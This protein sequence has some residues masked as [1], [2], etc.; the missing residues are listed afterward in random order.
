MIIKFTSLFLFVLASFITVA[1]NS[2]ETL[3]ATSVTQATYMKT[4]P[5]IADQIASGDFQEAIEINKEVNPKKRDANQ[6]VPGKGLPIGVDPLMHQQTKSSMIKGK[7]PILTFQAAAANVT[8]T[9]PT[10]AVGPNHFVNAWNSSFRIWDKEGNAMTPAASLG[11]IW[12]GQTMGDP[13]VMYDQIAD[14]FIITQFYGNG[15]LFA[16]SQG[17][18][19]I[20]SGWYTYQFPT[21]T[22]PD[23]PKYS[24]WSDGYYITSNKNSSSA[25]FSEVVYALDRDKMLTGDPSA[26]MIGFALPGIST[27][28]F[29]SPLGFN[30]TGP[31]M[32]PA[33]NAP[34]IYM[35]DDSWGGVSTDHLKI[36]NIN[37]DWDSPA[38]STISAAQ[39]IN[40]TP[41]D[42]LFDGGSFSNLPQPSGPDIDALQ[43]TIMYM[44]QYRRFNDHNSVVFNFVVDLTGS[45]NLAGIRW[46]ELRQENDGD[47]WEIFQEGTYSQPDGHSAY[48]GTMCMDA[49]GNIALAYTV[50]SNTVY[51]SL[52]YTGRFAT[53]DL[54]VMTIAEE[55]YAEG[56]SSSPFF[57]YGDYSQMTIDPEDDKTFWS[58][59]E[60]FNGGPRQNQVG[61]FKIAPD[62]ANDIGIISIDEPQN[63]ILTASEEITVTVR[64]FGVDDQSNFPVTYQIN[65][66][67]VITENFTGSLASNMDE[68]FTFS[69]LADLSNPGETFSIHAGTAL[70]TDLNPANDTISKAVT[71]LF[72]D[73]LGVTA[74]I[75]PES[76][77]YLS[78]EENI[79][80]T[81]YNYGAEIQSDF[82]ITYILND[83]TPVTET[84]T[85]S[86]NSE[87]FIDFEFDTPADFSVIGWHELKVT[88]DLSGD[89]NMDNDTLSVFVINSLCQP[90]LNCEQ[91]V[92][93]YNFELG[94]ITNETGCDP[95]GYGNY[96]NLST[97]L[98]KPAPHDLT[99]STEYG[100]TYVK[101]WIDYNDNFSFEEDEIV[102]DDFVIA[103]GQAAGNF[104][105]TMLLPVTN[106]ATL[107]EH[108]LR[109]KTNYNNNVPEDPCEETVF[110]E[111]EDYIVNIVLETGSDIASL[112]NNELHLINRGNNQYKVEYESNFMN[113]TMVLTIHDIRGNTL[114][115]N[116]VPS[117]NGSYHFEFD[118]SYAPKGVYLLRL[119]T[120]QFGKV[121][122][123]VIQ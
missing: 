82:N 3:E 32:P 29:Y 27:N 65:D 108:I 54:N 85:G 71:H 68:Q 63:G 105:E 61:V 2:N 90:D 76:G 49:Q 113:E 102:V 18:D 56:T 75:S 78:D 4:V 98:I 69:T 39:S 34:I 118:M 8:P 36:W 64:N 33:G 6:A 92:G 109:V 45:D 13:I 44:A 101:V 23:Y 51:P 66:G 59:A 70:D 74:V 116:K 57:R 96:T 73:D 28:G 19:P 38:S 117:Q 53:D 123:F 9:D 106:T 87:A 111:T 5:S 50:V 67:T 60:Y 81:L 112:E 42:G 47:D 41:F 21:S 12:P 17:P 104:T 122:R 16:I 110:G 62:L 119:G 83:E 43:A 94:S 120:D 40:T 24:I 48:S 107:G 30:V 95:G 26:E 93:I 37:V 31:E 10:G 91:G 25:G 89:Q 58:I 80:I 35:Q 77:V 52:R 100:N 88:T 72:A 55:S 86:V 22:F 99:I 97:I 15:F 11:T 79:S 114:I 14:R 46:Y 84:V 103:E 1:Q 7:D 115:S 121:K 20:N